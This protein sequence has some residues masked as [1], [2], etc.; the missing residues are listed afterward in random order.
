MSAAIEAVGIKL[1]AISAVMSDPSLNG[2]DDNIDPLNKI[3]DLE[4]KNDDI[5]KD[6]EKAY[7][8]YSDVNN[9]KNKKEYDEEIALQELQPNKYSNEDQ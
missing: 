2:S 9:M 7:A 5:L 1:G 8:I 3:N 4:T 6:V